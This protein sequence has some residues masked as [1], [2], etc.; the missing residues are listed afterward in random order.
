MAFCV[1]GGCHVGVLTF[2]YDRYDHKLSNDVF[3]MS[4]A[5]FCEEL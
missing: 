2:V 3:L 1:G 5:S 4:V